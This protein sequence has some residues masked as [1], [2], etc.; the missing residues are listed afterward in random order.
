MKT[1][2]EITQMA[3]NVKDR[4]IVVAGREIILSMAIVQFVLVQEGVL[5]VQQIVQQ[6][7]TVVKPV[8]VQL[9]VVRLVR[10]DLVTAIE[11]Q[12]MAVK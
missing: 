1:V 9:E 3:V 7:L 8:T 2:M 12:Q 11:M 5:P 6:S 10:L 4:P